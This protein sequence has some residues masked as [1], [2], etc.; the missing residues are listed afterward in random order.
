MKNS[1][2]LFKVIFVVF[3]CLYVTAFVYGDTG[4]C[5]KGN[6]TNGQGTMSHPDAENYEGKWKGGK[7]NGQGNYT[8]PSGKNYVGEFKDGL[9]NGQGTLI[10]TDGRVD[11][12]V[13]EKGKFVKALDNIVSEGYAYGDTGTCIKGNCTNGQ[14]TMRYPDGIKYVGEFKDGY[15]NGQGIRT[16]PAGWVKRGVWEKG[17]LIK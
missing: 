11:R 4:T 1:K 15:Y 2:S 5:I 6:C 14:G 7:F 3:I 9:F 10:Y 12:G 17:K 13:W 8:Y 16:Y